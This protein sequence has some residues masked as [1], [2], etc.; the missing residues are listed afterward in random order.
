MTTFTPNNM[1][2][3]S[4]VTP[5]TPQHIQSRSSETASEPVTAQ[6]TAELSPGQVVTLGSRTV[7]QVIV[8]DGVIRAKHLKPGQVVRAWLHGE[9]RGGERQVESVESIEGGAMVRITWAT[10]HPV[11]E[12]KAAYRYHD[13]TLEGQ[14]TVK[15]VRQRS[16]VDAR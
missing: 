1:P 14:R 9:P 11:S 6:I 5:I 15:R 3:R 13:K 7:E 4:T 16:F 2:A 12:V 10:E 8:H